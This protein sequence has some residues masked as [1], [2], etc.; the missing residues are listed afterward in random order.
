MDGFISAVI[1][2]YSR[3]VVSQWDTLSGCYDLE[4]IFL[5]IDSKLQLVCSN[6]TAFTF[7]LREWMA[8]WRQ[9]QARAKRF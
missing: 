8:I 6:L 3:N 1:F 7:Y 5:C 2:I 9:F 4:V